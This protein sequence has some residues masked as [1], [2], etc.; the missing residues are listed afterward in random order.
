ML[1]RHRDETVDGVAVLIERQADL[2]VRQ[3]GGK[4]LALDRKLELAARL[5]DLV[6]FG[7]FTDLD[8][9]VEQAIRAPPPMRVPL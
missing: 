8:L 5:E 3:D 1:A 7:R 9:D 4:V 2:E 6:A